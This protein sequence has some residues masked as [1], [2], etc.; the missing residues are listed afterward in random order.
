MATNPL[1][2]RMPREF[3]IGT[4]SRAA[5]MARS[6]RG[7]QP[8]FM[9]STVQV[10]S[11]EP[12]TVSIA[13]PQ[14]TANTTYVATGSQGLT[15]A[16]AAN[17]APYDTGNLVFSVMSVQA[18]TNTI[19][20]HPVVQIISAQGNPQVGVLASGQAYSG[21]T[22]SVS[23]TLYAVTTASAGTLTVQGNALLLGG[24]LGD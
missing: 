1:G 9:Q 4:G 23:V 13:T 5:S 22:V 11:V 21:L 7:V 10:G 8:S 6:G 18:P 19:A 20:S 3:T 17:L 2:N 16:S 24:V 12:V 14:I 15:R